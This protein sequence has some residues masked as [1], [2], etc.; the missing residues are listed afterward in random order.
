MLNFCI[1]TTTFSE[2]GFWYLDNQD[3]RWRFQTALA[4]KLSSDSVRVDED[5]LGPGEEQKT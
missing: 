4:A 1:F 2:L 3:G 5:V